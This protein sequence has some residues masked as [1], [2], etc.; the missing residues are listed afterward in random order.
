MRGHGMTVVGEN[1]P[2]AVFRA[3]YAQMNARLQTFASQLR[4]PSSS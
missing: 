1:I 2:E 4:A 3:V